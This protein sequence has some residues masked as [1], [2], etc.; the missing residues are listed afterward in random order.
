MDADSYEMRFLREAL[1]CENFGVSVMRIAEGFRQP[2]GHRHVHAEE[3]YLVVSGHA[4]LKLDDDI[5][6]L[7]PWKAVRVAPQTLRAVEGGDG[8][9]VIIVVGSPVVPGDGELVHGWWA[10]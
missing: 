9:A 5:L 3:V 4:R 2:F 6:E 1:G 7:T 10:D 8:G